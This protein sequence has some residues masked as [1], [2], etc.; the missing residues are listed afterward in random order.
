MRW[1]WSLPGERLSHPAP[2]PATE[3]ANSRAASLELDTSMSRDKI[4]R[5]ISGP[6]SS[7]PQKPSNMP[8]ARWAPPGA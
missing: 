3:T 2:S 6:L 7:R 1:G 4:D 8:R 5:G